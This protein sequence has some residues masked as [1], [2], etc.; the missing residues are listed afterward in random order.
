MTPQAFAGLHAV[1]YGD[2]TPRDVKAF[3]SL[4]NDPP[5]LANRR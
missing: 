5:V 2:E 4:M 1:A 3:E